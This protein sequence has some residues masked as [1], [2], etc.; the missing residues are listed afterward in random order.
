[1]SAIALNTDDVMRYEGMRDAYTDIADPGALNGEWLD[2]YR[3]RENTAIIESL[4][5]NEDN[6]LFHRGIAR[7]LQ[8]YS[9]ATLVDYLGDIPFSEANDPNNFNPAADDDEAIYT[10]ILTTID[11]AIADFNNATVAPNLDL[12]YNGDKEKWIKAANSLKFRLYL[13][14]RNTNGINTLLSSRNL[15]DSET[16]DFQ[17]QYT[18]V[19]VPADSRHPYF[20]RGYDPTDGQ[21]E[22]IGNFFM[23]LLKDSKSVRDPRLRYY[24]YRQ[25]SMEPGSLIDCTGDPIFDFCYIG[26]FYLGRDHGDD[27]PSPNDRFLK[28]IYG[29]YPGGGAFDG[30]NPIRGS[31]SSNLGGAGVFPV[32]LSSYMNFLKAEAALAL[33]TNGDAMALLEAGIRSSMNKVIALGELS[34]VMNTIVIE[35]DPNTTA[36][37]EERTIRDLFAATQTDVDRY[38]AEVMAEYQTADISRKLDIVMREYYIGRCCGQEYFTNPT[39]G[40]KSS[41]LGHIASRL[42]TITIKI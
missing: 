25:T 14:T 33:G 16:D 32:L 12:Y 30:N 29:I 38:V 39:T 3:L 9:M 36:V 18:N 35:D 21:G 10:E 37:N 41:L 2:V 5:E 24:F 42:F 27:S 1:M 8:A 34:E 19:Q 40:Y 17:F 7:I 6:L 13:N 28:T 31:D 23:S 26:E 11:L 4:A 20:Q 15:I 22:Y